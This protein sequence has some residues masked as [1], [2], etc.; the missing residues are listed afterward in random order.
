MKETFYM[1]FVEGGNTPTYKHKSQESAE[2]EA[3]RLARAFKKKAFVL[4]TVKSFEIIEFTEE[5][6]LPDNYDV[7]PEL[8]W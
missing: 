2:T 6:C 4:T 7:K 8:P 5:E 3:K 1:V